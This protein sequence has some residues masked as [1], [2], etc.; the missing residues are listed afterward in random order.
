MP[1]N[2]SNLIQSL[3]NTEKTPELG[4]YWQKQYEFVLSKNLFKLSKK[5]LEIL[6]YTTAN[7]PA[8]PIGEIVLLNHFDEERKQI[9]EDK[10]RQ[11]IA[12]SVRLL[13]ALIDRINF[14]KDTRN[15]VEKYRKIGICL[16]DFSSYQNKI[17]DKSEIDKIDYIGNLISQN[18]YRAS[19]SLAEEKGTCVEWN[20]AKKKL[21]KKPFENWINTETNEIFNS[22]DLFESYTEETIIDSKFEIIPRRNT[23][24]LVFFPEENWQIWSDRDIN[25]QRLITLNFVENDTKV[26]KNVIMNDTDVIKKSPNSAEFQVGELVQIKGTKTTFQIFEINQK[27]DAYLYKLEGLNGEMNKLFEENELENV[28]LEYILNKINV[29]GK[30]EKSLI[31]A[32]AVIL[33]LKKDK[34]LL[35]NGDLLSVKFDYTERPE[36]KLLDLLQAEVDP[37]AEIIDEIG[38]AFDKDNNLYL[39]FE[40]LFRNNLRF[41][42]KQKNTEWKWFDVHS[43]ELP[44]HIYIILS[45]YFFRKEKQNKSNSF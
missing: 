43:D 9:D 21:R 7:N 1:D 25:S 5:T 44:N 3:A 15:L 11:T 32:S 19:E 20:Q 42:A 2:F 27:G 12:I 23:H 33:N 38:T 6:D 18:A 13:D 39:G 24:L 37:D 31:M 35:K 30:N 16:A 34:I 45:K 10:I 4:A 8:T 28:Q 29:E 17:S 26:N 22:L 40:T 41:L 36:F 14:T